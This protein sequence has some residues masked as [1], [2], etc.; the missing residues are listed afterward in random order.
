[1]VFLASPRSYPILVPVLRLRI[2][3]AAADLGMLSGCSASTAS[4]NR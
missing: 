1:M 2:F 3:Q 4:E